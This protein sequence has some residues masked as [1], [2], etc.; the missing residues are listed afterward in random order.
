MK[1]LFYISIA[2]VFLFSCSKE[3]GKVVYKINF[4]SSK[5]TLKSGTSV[6][7]QKSVP[8]N[9]YTQFGDYITCLTPQKLT[10]HIWTVGY[11]DTVLNVNSDS[12]LLQYIEQNGEKLSVN[13]SS[14]FIVFSDNNIVNFNAVMYG[15]FKDGLF[16]KPQI[17]FNYFY[18]IPFNFYQ[19]LQLP[20][21]YKNVWLEMFNVMVPDNKILNLGY[22]EMLHKIFPNATVNDYICFIFGKTNSTYVVNANSETVAGFSE[23]CP[24][25]D[26]GQRMVIRSNKYS[27]MTFNKPQDGAT[28]VM[29]GTLSFDTDGLIQV[30]AGK[31][32]IPYTSDDIFVYEPNFWERIYSKLDI[33]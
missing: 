30:Y 8:T 19:K 27:L 29:N 32:N 21:Q 2:I 11:I 33:D 5:I 26:P 14:R 16:E 3:N 9:L 31:D 4:T 22:H 17:D 12:H 13:D 28:V 10:A 24:V 18:F 7:D 25:A 6:I 20:E 23:N 1:K 15:Q